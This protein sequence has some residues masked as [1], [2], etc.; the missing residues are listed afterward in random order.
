M[1]IKLFQ[2]IVIYQSTVCRVHRVHSYLF[3]CPMT[4]IIIIFFIMEIFLL[5]WP[6]PY[7]TSGGGNEWTGF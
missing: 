2:N 5:F 3:M 7:L 6:G 1:I 4:F